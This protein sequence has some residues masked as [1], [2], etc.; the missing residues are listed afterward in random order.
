MLFR[1]GLNA[2]QVQVWLGH[3]SPAFTLATY[4]HLLRDD[5]PSS[6]FLDPLTGVTTARDSHTEHD[7]RAGIPPVRE[8]RPVGDASSQQRDVVSSRTG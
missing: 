5:L 8:L 1:H 2:K 6:D 7:S 3:H 4:V